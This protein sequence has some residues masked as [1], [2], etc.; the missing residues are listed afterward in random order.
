MGSSDSIHISIVIPVYNEER[1]IV[2][3]LEKITNYFG[4]CQENYEIIVVDDGST[5]ATVP[6]VEKF[7]QQNNRLKLLKNSANCG[8]GKTVQTGVLN[9]QGRWIYFTDADLST[10]IEEIELF[11]KEIQ[12]VDIVI[13]SRSL[14]ESQI[15]I[16]EPL[17]REILG[18]AF[19]AVVRWLCVPGFQDTQCGA[20]MFQREAA[21]KIFPLLKIH[22]FAFDVE[23]LYLAQKF[24]FKVKE[25]PIQWYYSSDTRVRTFKDGFWMLL[26]LLKIRW[27]HRNTK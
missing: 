4:R 17:Y 24:Q 22:R 27:I 26:D 1:R 7:L 2:P 19:C 3:T 20:K 21:L 10:P 25:I 16:H 23:I 13:G 5:D 6:V 15:V 12:N 9:S 18:K 8:K 11:L 14:R